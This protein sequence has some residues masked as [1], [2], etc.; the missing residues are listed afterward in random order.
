MSSDQVR[1]HFNMATQCST[2]D[3]LNMVIILLVCS[4]DGQLYKL[5]TGMHMPN[6]RLLT[7]PFK[8][9]TIAMYTLKRANMS[10]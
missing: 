2:V 6:A 3:R 5:A 7:P 1:N 10:R 4:C 8:L 9:V